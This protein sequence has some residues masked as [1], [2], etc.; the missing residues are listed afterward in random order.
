MKIPQNFLFSIL[1]A[2]IIVSCSKDSEVEPEV[3]VKTPTT[4]VPD[5]VPV[6]QIQ[7]KIIA[8]SSNYGKPSEEITI[9]GENF[10]DKIENIILSFDGVNA[11]IISATP[12]AIKFKLPATNNMIPIL[13]LVIANTKITNTVKNAYDGNIAILNAN[14]A[15]SWIVSASPTTN[16]RIIKI[17]ILDNGAIYYNYEITSTLAGGSTIS[18]NYVKRSLD[19]GKTWQT[20]TETASSSMGTN[21]CATTNDEGWSVYGSNDLSKIPIGGNNGTGIVKNLGMITNMYVDENLNSGTII[22]LAGI[23]YKTID[24]FTFTKEYDSSID[25]KNVMTDGSTSLDNDHIWC[26]GYKGYSI[27]GVFSYW[28][29]IIYKKGSTEQWKE[30]VFLDAGFTK[31]SSISTLQF[32]KNNSGLMLVKTSEDSRILKSNDGGD[33]WKEIYKGEKF[34]SMSFIDANNGWAILGKMIYKTNDGGISWSLDYTHD[35]DILKI[36]SKDKLV[37]AFSKTKIIK[38]YL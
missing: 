7:A 36:E 10:S 9:T 29:F 16:S 14:P 33:N 12:T 27:D 37:I 13:S 18:F 32:F 15:S 31:G 21:F 6:P 4:P 28:P 23:V 2:L 5:P 11:T 3:V 35:E 8:Y 17:Q 19:D 1:L 25:N 26:Y 24:G 38:R 20:W 30:K 22:T 34:T